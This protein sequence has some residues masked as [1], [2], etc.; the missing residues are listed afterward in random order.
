MTN[1]NMIPDMFAHEAYD[2][3]MDDSREGCDC[4]GCKGCQGCSGLF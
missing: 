1:F 4:Q 2:Q 3:D